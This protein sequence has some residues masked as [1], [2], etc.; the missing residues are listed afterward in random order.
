MRFTDKFIRMELKPK[1][2][3]K[4]ELWKL[5][6][7]LLGATNDLSYAL[8]DE[9][10]RLMQTGYDNTGAELL[11]YATKLGAVGNIGI[12]LKLVEVTREQVQASAKKTK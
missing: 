7:E 6:I 5:D 3:T 8:V 12:A 1:K 9:Y 10:V 11:E 4:V 2:L